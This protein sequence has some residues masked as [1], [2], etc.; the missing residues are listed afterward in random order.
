MYKGMGMGIDMAWG[1]KSEL[2]QKEGGNVYDTTLIGTLNGASDQ[3]ALWN[4]PCREIKRL[5][6]VTRKKKK[7][8]RNATE[9]S[10][11]KEHERSGLKVVQQ[12]I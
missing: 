9:M 8:P 7:Y 12:I 1:W 10:R 3:V 5:R 4:K 6:L 2:S 11:W